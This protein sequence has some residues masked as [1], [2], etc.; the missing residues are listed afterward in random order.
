MKAKE[1]LENIGFFYV[2]KGCHCWF[3]QKFGQSVP[4]TGNVKFVPSHAPSIGHH[5]C[6]NC[7]GPMNIAGP[8]WLSNLHDKTFVKSVLNHIMDRDAYKTKSRMLGM[9]SLVNE[10]LTNSSLYYTL[11]DL[12][13]VMHC[14]MP[15][16]K[17][18]RSVLL[19]ANY[20]VSYSHCN[21]NSIKTD[22]PNEFIWQIMKEWCS[23]HSI[24]DRWLKEEF[25]AFQIIKN[26][27]TFEPTD[28]IEKIDFTLREDAL[29]ESKKQ[30]LVRYQ[31]SPPFW[32]PKQKPKR[33]NNDND[34]KNEKT[35]SKEKVIILVF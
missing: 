8:L 17:I 3:E 27:P 5:K 7:N 6:P 13:S 31:V 29:P 12:C 26:V 2:C 14:E 33:K 18:F 15:V 10:E 34:D 24:N 11:D 25:R 28:K 1:S 23:T 4:T 19:N 21:K 9:L 16:M 35:I 22:A 32:G 20:Q 30:K